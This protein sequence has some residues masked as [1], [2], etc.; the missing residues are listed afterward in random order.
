MDNQLY[1][2]AFP[3]L[4]YGVKVKE[5]SN[6]FHMTLIQSYEY[7]TLQYYFPYFAVLLQEIKVQMDSTSLNELLNFLNDTQ[8]SSPQM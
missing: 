7:K 6:I 5:D 8:F 1:N 3:V 4:L 2:A